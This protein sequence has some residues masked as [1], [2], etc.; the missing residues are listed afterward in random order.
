MFSTLRNFFFKKKG[1]NQ[2]KTNYELGFELFTCEEIWDEIK[3]IEES[4]SLDNFKLDKINSTE[5]LQGILDKCKYCKDYYDLF[6]DHLYNEHSDAK[7]T[8][9]EPIPKYPEIPFSVYYE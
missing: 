8:H 4:K 5:F 7:F 9:R 3:K 1:P 2:F 6:I